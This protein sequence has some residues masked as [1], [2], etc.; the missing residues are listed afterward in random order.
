MTFGGQGFFGYG[1]CNLAPQVNDSDQIPPVNRSDQIPSPETPLHEAIWWS[2]YQV[3]T[4]PSTTHP[5][6]SAI[7]A[8]LQSRH[9]NWKDPVIQIIISTA[10]VDSIY[11][12]W[13]TPQL[14]TWS[15]RN[16]VLVGDAAHALQPT[17]GQ[18]ASQALEDAQ[19]L[20]MLLAHFLHQSH[21]Q[22]PSPSTTQFNLSQSEA[23]PLA[24]KKYEE[25]RKPRVT[26]I[27]ERSKRMGDM[28]RKKGLLEEWM[29]YF[30]IWLMGKWGGVG[31]YE[32]MLRELP[33]YEVR[34]F[35]EAEK[36]GEQRE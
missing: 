1:P 12:T 18:G 8:Q 17:S 3:D 22:S 4:P 6:L 35:I 26:A 24:L 13:T 14:P 31:G 11:P 34:R 9:S 16:T 30:F 32:R 20:S 28:K 27:Q 25:I 5:D 10:T 21:S 7:K 19:V 33:V 29:T 15:N 23:I 36:K 2:T